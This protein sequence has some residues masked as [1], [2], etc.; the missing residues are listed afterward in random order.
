MKL[1]DADI[2]ETLIIKSRIGILYPCI[3]ARKHL[4]NISL[5]FEVYKFI[6]KYIFKVE[7]SD[8]KRNEG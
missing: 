6:H 8:N 2:T 4:N 1:D 7:Q 5:K 3:Y